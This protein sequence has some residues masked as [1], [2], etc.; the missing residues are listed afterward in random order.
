MKYCTRCL[1]PDTRPGIQFDEH[2]VCLPCINFEKIKTTDWNQRKK[3]LEELCNK[4]RECNG[5]YHDCIIAV[6]GGKDSHFQVYYMKEIMKMNSLLV[7]N[8]NFEWTET[9]RKNLKN[10]S[11]FFGC[12]ILILQPN[13]KLTKKILRKAFEVVGASS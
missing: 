1:I 5:N 11:E 9:G 8:G 2:G 3:E 13:R 12:D 10:F 7:S 6:S 4:H